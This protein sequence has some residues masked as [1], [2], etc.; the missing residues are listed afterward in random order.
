MYFLRARTREQ[1]EKR[2]L[3]IL[4]AC[5]KLFIAGGYENVNIKAISEMT[6]IGRSSIYTYYKTKEE[7]LLD[8]LR[9]ELAGWEEEL[10]AWR[11]L[12]AEMAG[13]AA[14]R[15]AVRA[16]CEQF[17]DILM[18]HEKM[19]RYFCLLYTLLEKNCRL[20]K[21]V[22]FKREAVPVIGRIAERLSGRFPMLSPDAADEVIHQFIGFVLGMYPVSHLTP[23][24][25]RAIELS[26]TG[27]APLDFRDAVVGGMEAF[28][29][30]QIGK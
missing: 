27:Y 19:L 11:E 6:T 2:Q 13:G 21:L 4:Q 26:R 9:M 30:R 20:E 12:S 17:A 10:F 1:I 23:K 25:A 14:N 5:E 29:L 24:Q 8:L 16:F 28:L 3:E 7:M 22:E 18:E 15:A